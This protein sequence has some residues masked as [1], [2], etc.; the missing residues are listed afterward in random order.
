MASMGPG[1]LLLLTILVLVVFHYFYGAAVKSAFA[2]FGSEPTDAVF[3]LYYVDWCPH[4]KSVKPVFNEFMG[5][6]TALING[7]AVKV[8]MIN[9]ESQPDAVAG[10]NIRG[11]P[12]FM[13]N[14]NGQDI[15]Y[16]GPRNADGWAAFLKEKILA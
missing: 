10:K 6:G 14:T 7:K 12:T 4:C 8:R 5:N 11:Y 2:N 13:L 1:V 15:E 3:T 16:Q 9:P